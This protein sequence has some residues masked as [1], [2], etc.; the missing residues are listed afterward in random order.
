MEMIKIKFKKGENLC[1]KIQFIRF[2]VNENFGLKFFK[3]STIVENLVILNPPFHI[4]NDSMWIY[5]AIQHWEAIK[6]QL[7]TR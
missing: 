5:N 3:I 2:C 4:H 6:D 1:N 7:L